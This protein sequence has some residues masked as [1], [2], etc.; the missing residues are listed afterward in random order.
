VL[1]IAQEAFFSMR[2]GCYSGDCVK[3]VTLP[4]YFGNRHTYVEVEIV[5]ASK[6]VCIRI[7]TMGRGS[8]VD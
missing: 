4:S 7:E 3:T 1:A 5:D 8:V 6:S 2:L